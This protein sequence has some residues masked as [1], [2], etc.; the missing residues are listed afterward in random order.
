MS[1]PLFRDAVVA[2]RG[3]RLCGELIISQPLPARLL[4]A[5]LAVATLVAAGWLASNSYQRKV[6]VPGLLVPDTGVVELVAPFNGRVGT[7]YVQAG[8]QVEAG[9]ALFSVENPRFV[10]GSTSIGSGL[11]HSLGE[12][13]AAL[14]QQLG[15]E[16]ANEQ[17][18]QQDFDTRQALATAM[19]E[20]RRYAL[21]R[22]RQLLVIRERQ[23]G[24]AS[25]LRQ[26]E[27][28]A[29]ADM[30]AVEAQLLL[31]QQSV[32]EAVLAEQQVANELQ[33]LQQ[34][35]EE[36]LGQSRQLQQRLLAE[37]S[38]N[39]RQVLQQQAD[40]QS[41]VVAPVAG[42]VTSLQA[43]PGMATRAQQPLVALLPAT[44]TL[45]LELQVPSQAMGFVAPGQQVTYRLDAFPYQKF[46]VQQARTVSVPG[47]PEQGEGGLPFY[48]VV[49]ALDHSDIMAYGA[50]QPLRPG[51]LASADIRVDERTLL[52]W[53]LEPLYSIK[54]Y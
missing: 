45:R 12:Q 7:V 43:K 9:T 39:D 47:T 53:L 5:L 28:L 31:Q 10:E 24:R 14:R 49:A 34:Q 48:R 13:A 21:E 23:A 26:G 51:M 44:A 37:L 11:L 2:A 32:A 17:R 6:T 16:R 36:R 33:Q 8:Q 3:D 40:Q 20:Q 15:L 52:Q 42:V 18:W 4:A 35:H 19:L 38:Q 25:Q 27:L 54:G 41:V 29:A 22:Q 1:A 50:E 30:D 46:G